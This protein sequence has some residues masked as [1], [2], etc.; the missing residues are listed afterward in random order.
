LLTRW[1]ALARQQ[2]FFFFLLCFWF[3]IIPSNITNYLGGL[4]SVSFWGFFLANL[5]GRL[6]SLIFITFIGAD[7]VHLSWPHWLFIAG[8]GLISILAGRY[9]T[10]KITA[11]FSSF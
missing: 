5:L 8:L 4:A 9:L 7:G 6:P 3:P 1:Q 11:R 10:T 2:G